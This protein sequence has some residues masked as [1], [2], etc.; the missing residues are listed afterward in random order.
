MPNAADSSKAAKLAAY[1]AALRKFEESK[2]AIDA[3][4]LE[5]EQ[6]ADDATDATS[7]Q[8]ASTISGGDVESVASLP[9]PS[10]TPNTGGIPPKPWACNQGSGLDP[11]FELKP[12]LSIT[13]VI[14]YVEVRVLYEHIIEELLI[15]HFLSFRPIKWAKIVL[16]LSI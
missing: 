6:E 15:F 9:N 2:K 13:D 7:I 14:K 16:F 10:N 11:E 5:L 1:E 12:N 8:A 4:K 3:L